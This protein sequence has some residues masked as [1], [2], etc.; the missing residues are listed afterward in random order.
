[1][2]TN[3][4]SELRVQSLGFTFKRKSSNFICWMK[5]LTSSNPYYANKALF[6]KELNL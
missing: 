6:N 5:D 1:M 2:K 4:P 3:P